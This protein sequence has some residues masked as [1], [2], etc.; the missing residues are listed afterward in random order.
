[1]PERAIALLV[2]ILRRNGGRLPSEEHH[3]E[4]RCLSAD[5]VERVE[6]LYGRCFPAAIADPAR[7]LS[8]NGA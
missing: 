5:E 1:M 7:M 4:F 3:G 6:E 8:A 2:R